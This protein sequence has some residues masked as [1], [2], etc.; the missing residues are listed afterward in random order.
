MELLTSVSREVLL[1]CVVAVANK[2]HLHQALLYCC[3]LRPL[4]LVCKYVK[5][6]GW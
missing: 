6:V 5:N 1:D 4:Q 3:E 2:P